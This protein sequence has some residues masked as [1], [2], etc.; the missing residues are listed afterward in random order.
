MGNMITPGGIAEIGKVVS[1][2]I[3]SI[4]DY[5]KCREYEITERQRIQACLRAITHQI[6]S[7]RI[8]FEQYMKASFAERELLYSR[9]DKL[10]NYAIEAGDVETAKLALNTILGIYHKDPME[11][12]GIALEPVNVNLL[13]KGFVNYLE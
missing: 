8:K 9:V 12:F 3:N 13:N 6:D 7:N 1:D 2:T 4:T 11:G 10:L 5:M